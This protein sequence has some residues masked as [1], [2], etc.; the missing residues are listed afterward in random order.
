MAG[1]MRRSSAQARR[2]WGRHVD[3]QSGSSVTVAEYC[4]QHGLC[5]ASFY[6]WRSRLARESRQGED[7]FREVVREQELASGV[8]GVG[9]EVVS[10]RVRVTDP[11]QLGQVLQALSQL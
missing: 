8:S 7:G 11:A 3:E 2:F 1:G 10:V 4:R 5:Q 9:I 6:V